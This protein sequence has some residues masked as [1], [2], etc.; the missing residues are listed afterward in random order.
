MRWGQW[1]PNMRHDAPCEGEAVRMEKPLM[2]DPKG[3]M[4][5]RGPWYGCATCG[6]IAQYQDFVEAR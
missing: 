6:R 4:T 2:S 5:H 3:Y 1:S